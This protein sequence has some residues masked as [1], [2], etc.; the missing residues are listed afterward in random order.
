MK[1]DLFQSCGHCRVFKI[2]CHIEYSTLTANKWVNKIQYPILQ[3][4]VGNRK[5]QSTDSC[6]NI[7]KL[8]KYYAQ[9]KKPVT[10]D[11]LLYDVFRIGK[12]IKIESRFAVA[13]ISWTEEPGGLQCVGSQRVGHDEETEATRTGLW[14]REDRMRCDC[15]WVGGFFWGWWKCLKIRIWW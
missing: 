10:K 7:D 8:W 15:S 11:H 3:I 12:Y 4:L 6:Y 1:I 5:G 9:W 14:M 13:W 2:C